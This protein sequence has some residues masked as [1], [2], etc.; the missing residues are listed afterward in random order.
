MIIKHVYVKNFM[1][2]ISR[3]QGL[4]EGCNVDKCSWR[5]Q[6]CLLYNTILILLYRALYSN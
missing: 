3:L 2:K 6:G 1:M 5:I 4:E